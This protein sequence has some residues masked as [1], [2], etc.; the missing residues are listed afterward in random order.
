M[1][2]IRLGIVFLINEIRKLESPVT[3]VTEI[4][5]TI[6]GYN[7][8]VTARAE[9]IPSTRTVIGL[10]LMIGVVNIFL[11]IAITILF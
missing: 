10:A 4:P 2:L 5:I 8:T 9:Q 1:I 6:A 7:L 11:S 3:R